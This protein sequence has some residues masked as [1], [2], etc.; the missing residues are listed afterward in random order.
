MTFQDEVAIVTGAGSGIGRSVAR[1]LAAE[2]A[3]VVVADLNRATAL[4]TSA[5]I[6]ESSG[7]AIA[8]QVDVSSPTQVTTLASQSL[9]R[10]GQIDIL[11]NSAGVSGGHPFLEMEVAEWDRVLSVN[12][13]GAFLC[14]QAVARAMVQAGRGGKIINITSVNSEIAA[15][16]ISHYCASKGGLRMLTKVLAIEL[17]PHKINVNAVGPGIIDTNLTVRSMNDP[18]RLRYLMEQVPWRRVG[19]PEDVAEAV[20]FLASERADYITGSTL[21]VD[22]GWLTG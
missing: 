16:G 13:K 8:I 1:H 20:L 18:D 17:A 9:E 19:Q 2:G 3:R 7:K 12:L 22:G 5:Q 4:E 21:W 14:S 11:V 10:W 6:K 15:P